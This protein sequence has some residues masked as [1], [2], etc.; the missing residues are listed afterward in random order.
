MRLYNLVLKWP[1]FAC[2]LDLHQN[3][4]VDKGKY[5]AARVCSKCGKVQWVIRAGIR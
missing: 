2:W 4:E 1:A 3:T 5:G